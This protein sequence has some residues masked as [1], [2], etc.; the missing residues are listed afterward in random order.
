MYNYD[1]LCR[2]NTIFKHGNIQNVK[3]VKLAPNG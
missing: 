1:I 3:Y 2:A